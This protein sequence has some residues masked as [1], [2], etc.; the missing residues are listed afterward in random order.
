MFFFLI[1]VAGGLF[2]K[3]GGETTKSI[4]TSLIASAIVALATLL[5]EQLRSSEQL[6]ASE[7]A[8]AGIL[9]AYP[10]RDLEEY[11]ALVERSRE[12][13]V[14]GYT[15]RAFTEANV[16]H[17]RERQ[18]AGKPIRVRMLLVDSQTPFSKAMQADEGQP[19]GS[20]TKSQTAIVNILR[21]LDSC[22][23]IRKID[24]PITAMLYRIDEVAYT[25]SYPKYTPSTHANTIKIES[26][27]WIFRQLMID[28]EKMW[29]NADKIDIS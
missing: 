24:T 4:G 16:K 18:S 11:D 19:S 15:L 3:Y 28:F 2:T 22:I 26:H 13:D 25:G 29:K 7:L 27:G 8:K 20:Y 17:F 12:I 14:S 5:I 10:R 23:E 21:G 1:L 6:R 9:A